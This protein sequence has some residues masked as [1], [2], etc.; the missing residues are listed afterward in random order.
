MSIEKPQ[1]NC[2]DS[3]S[4]S[5]ILALTEQSAV[6]NPL[7]RPTDGQ[8]AASEGNAA[9]D[10]SAPTQKLQSDTSSSS[11]LAPGI[12]QQIGRYRVQGILGAGGC[13]KVYLAFDTQLHRPVAI[14]GPHRV[15]SPA[16]EPAD[17][18]LAGGPRA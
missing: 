17:D 11:S 6:M 8:Q 4:P 12:P 10:T 5:G 7:E 14:K 2:Y 13:G 16:P 3:N 9:L 18:S 1:R 15:A